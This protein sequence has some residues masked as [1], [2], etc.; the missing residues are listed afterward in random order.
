MPTSLCYHC[1][2]EWRGSQW[3]ERDQCLTEPQLQ[4]A[5]TVSSSVFAPL[6]FL[7]PAS[8]GRHRQQECEAALCSS[9]LVCWGVSA[10]SRTDCLAQA[11][12]GWTSL[13]FNPKRCNAL[14]D[15]CFCSS[16]REEEPLPGAWARHGLPFL[17]EALMVTRW[18]AKRGE[19]VLPLPSVLL[20]HCIFLYPLFS[21][22]R[23]HLFFLPRWLMQLILLVTKVEKK[24]RCL[25]NR[26]DNEL[27]V[28]NDS[29]KNCQHWFL[30]HTLPR[31][32]AMWDSDLDRLQ[33]TDSPVQQRQ[34]HLMFKK[35]ILHQPV[36]VSVVCF[37]KF[38]DG[39]THL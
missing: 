19:V 23:C 26:C 1:G 33:S 3:L 35:K 21:P 14:A 22:N 32:M 20:T 6:F 25:T 15:G 39:R 29:L 8:L 31:H 27:H 13:L 38:C 30:F 10:W 24:N 7:F 4:S 17:Y 34:K 2:G 11:R 16:G 28:L 36:S 18:W 5:S 37:G 12:M 9:L